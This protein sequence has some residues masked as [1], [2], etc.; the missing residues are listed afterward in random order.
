MATLCLQ[1][2][3]TGR[4]TALYIPPETL[5]EQRSDVV[6]RL[7]R[8]PFSRVHYRV[9][10]ILSVGTFFDAFDAIC[11]ATALTVIFT[12]LN[13]GFMHAGL[14]FGSSFVGQFIG[15]WAFGVLSERYGRKP[16]FVTS[17]LVFGA[18][19]LVT[20]FAWDLTSLVVMRA[21]QGIGLGGEVPVAAVL[22]SELLRSKRRGQVG[23]LYQSIFQWGALLTP[24]LG[25]VFFNLF[26]KELGWRVMFAFGGLPV[27]F[28]IYAWFR[29]PE[30]PRWLVD[31]GRYDEADKLLREMENQDWPQPLEE[32]E[33]TP[34]PP[35]EESRF[36]E[37]F[38]GTYRRRTIMAWCV[39]FCSYFVA[40][41]FSLWL[42]TLY[43]KIGGLQVNHAVALS[44]VPWI[45]GMS[46]VYLG[47]FFV[48]RIGR[49]PLI[50]GGLL[51]I[52]LAGFGGAIIIH[53]W[54]TTTWQVLFGLGILLSVGSS[55]CTAILFT[56]T[57]ELYP[58][59]I[60]GL[61]VSA[62]SSMLR[63]AG[64]I[65]PAAVGACLAAGFG[66][67]SVF[68]MFGAA[69]LLGAVVI[70]VLGNET[71]QKNLESLAP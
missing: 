29:L 63:L 33:R 65:A 53:G 18:L 55:Q 30:S 3:R 24:V 56:Y 40:Y 26:G 21:I 66:I 69:G 1:L 36:G 20:A 35:L 71:R 38:G 54:H 8:L 42:P 49:K 13:I 37:L 34:L 11:I 32:P 2:N 61:G 50:I 15:A 52:A 4:G 17:L 9:A 44:I 70:A 31:R 27:L 23:I 43:V 41:G 22:M 45:S 67:E 16:A 39:W 60:R 6:A 46:L 47:S 51:T 57:S 62:G 14:V 19:S 25:L 68:A 59:R 5:D 10:S 48:D 12:S 64:I 28:A 7:E 58:T